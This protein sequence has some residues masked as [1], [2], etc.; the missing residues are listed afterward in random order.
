MKNTKITDDVRKRAD[1]MQQIGQRAVDEAREENR[2]LGLPNVNCSID[3]TLT[4]ELP[5]GTITSESPFEKN[6]EKA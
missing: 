2:R 5:D 4:Y 1:E 3:E 6:D